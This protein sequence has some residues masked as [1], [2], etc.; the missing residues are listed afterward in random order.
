VLRFPRPFA[1]GQNFPNANLVLGQ[2]SFRQ[3]LRGV[4]QSRM[5]SPYGLAFSGDNAQNGLLVCDTDDVTEEQ[6]PGGHRVLLFRGRPQDL[7]SGMSAGRVF[8]QADYNALQSGT[9]QNRLSSPRHIAVDSDDRLYVADAG[10]NRIMIFDRATAAGGANGPTAGTVLTTGQENSGLSSPRG[11]YV[12]PVTGEIWVSEGTQNRVMRY[13]RFADLGPGRNFANFTLRPPGGV[14]A[15]TQDPLGN[16]LYLETSNRLAVHY[17]GFFELVNGASYIVGRPLAPGAIATVKPYD[18]G[19]RFSDRDVVTDTATWPLLLND[20]QVLVG[21]TPAPVHFVSAGQI[22]FL[23]PMSAP[24]SGAI[25]VQVVKQSTGQILAAG[26]MQMAPASPA[27]FTTTGR[28]IAAI[29][30]DGTV[31]SV[32]DRV[33]R[34]KIIALFGTGQGFVNG[35]PRDGVPPTGAVETEERPR[36]NLAGSFIPEENILY[37]GL[38]PQLVGVWQIN[39]KIPDTVLPS[40]AVPVILLYKSTFSSTTAAN[41]GTIAVKQE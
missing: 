24:Q 39:I 1:A 28:Q 20:I 10:N 6:Q 38:A 36:V 34:G 33:G 30:E 19:S 12:N 37:S 25:E 23:V 27:L 41:T 35:A 11:V 21:E 26:P 22:N 29:N 32:S 8:G 3:R 15:V 16:V 17:P 4:S 13:P 40:P 9:G 2:P 31:N 14:L 7:T 5:L 18:T